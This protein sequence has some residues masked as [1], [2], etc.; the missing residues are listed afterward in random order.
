MEKNGWK[1]KD[2]KQSDMDS[3][4]ESKEDIR[5]ES[6]DVEGHC[7]GVDHFFTVLAAQRMEDSVSKLAP[8]KMHKKCQW[9]KFRQGFGGKL[10]LGL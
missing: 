3:S 7:S 2:C 9:Q 10:E 5:F 1:G 4:V 8:I 6:S